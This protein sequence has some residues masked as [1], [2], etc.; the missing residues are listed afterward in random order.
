MGFFFNSDFFEC[1]GIVLAEIFM[2]DKKKMEA[3]KE[4]TI[5]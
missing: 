2:H 3:Y 5:A 1:I 4:R